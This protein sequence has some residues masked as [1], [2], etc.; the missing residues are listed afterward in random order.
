MNAPF[1]QSLSE[2][3]KQYEF[4]RL[5]YLTWDRTPADIDGPQQRALKAVLER[6]SGAQF[7]KTAYVAQEARVFTE[8]LVMGEDT[9]IA[10]H[11]L[12]RGDVVLGDNTTVNPYVC[13]SGRVHCGSGVR[14]AS[15]ASLVG[16]NHGFDDPD[17]P[18]YKQKHERLGIDIGDDVWIGANAVIVDGVR[19]GSGA[20]IAAGAVVTRN[21][22]DKAIVAG[23]PAKVVRKR[24]QRN[25]IQTSTYG[26]AEIAYAKLGKSAADQWSEILENN[27]ENGA[28]ISP[29]S[30]GIKRPSIRHLCD[31][32]EIASAFGSAPHCI[33]TQ[34]AISCLLAVQDEQT[35]LFPDPFRP[36]PDASAMRHDGLALYNVLAVG[37]AL[38]CLNA[39]PRYSIEAIET[40]ST[41]ELC[42]WLD[43]LPWVSQAWSAGATVDAIG[44]ALYFNARYF[45]S[46]THLETMLGW[47]HT[48]CNPN[49]GLWGEPSQHGNYLQ[50]VNGFYRLSRGTYA[51]FGLPL[52]YP[53]A[54]IDTVLAHY[55]R[56]EGFKGPTHTA[57]NLLD[58]VH[59]LWLARKQ[60]AYRHS[61]IAKVAENIILKAAPTW[62]TGKGFAFASKQPA[63]LQ[64]TEM[65]LS[66][67][68]LCADIL[69]FADGATF[70]P[71]GVHR[72]PPALAMQ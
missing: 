21:V 29:E 61:D 25:A 48:R 3:E 69:G 14:I 15:H 68:Y 35:G 31:A 39:A 34:E 65:W 43:A 42:A 71:K 7:A 1:D 5:Q 47:L 19:I 10:G 23:V 26:R 60:T 2:I 44:T 70:E 72:L 46:G 59:P 51:Q 24:G 12:L 53:K 27:F 13:I 50:P 20:V 37:Y 17:M 56:H 32:I 40:L 28:F 18:I 36:R 66:I 45:D 9:W 58:V 63:S 57:C 22:P 54:A 11:A 30:D 49:T 33:D 6:R 67:L 52:P 16:F 38:E 62:E 64:G 55:E 8:R 4:A 41:A